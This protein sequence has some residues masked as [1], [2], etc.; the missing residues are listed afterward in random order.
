MKVF[1]LV[2]LLLATSTFSTSA[3]EELRET[4]IAKARVES[5]GGWR[6]NRLPEVKKFIHEDIPLF[7]NAKFKPV[8][9]APP[10]LVLLNRFDQVVERIALD[11]LNREECNQLMLKKGFYKKTTE[12]EEV[13]EQYLNGPYREREEL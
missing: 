10:E 11:K 2:T 13:P 8:G 3:E 4:E 7:H 5:C 9:G 12:D 6:L 1:A